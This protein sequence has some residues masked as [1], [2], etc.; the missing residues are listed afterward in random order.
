MESRG[1]DEELTPGTIGGRK[2]LI[3]GLGILGGGIAMARYL[4]DHGA[5]LRITDLRSAA[6]LAPALEALADVPAE[7]RLGAHSEADVRWA[8]VVIRNPGVR[9]DDRFLA[10]ARQLGRPVEMEMSFFFRWTP[11]RLTAVTGTKGKTTTTT[12][13]HNLLQADER[14]IHLTGNMGLPAI[15]LLDSLTPAD[16][17]LVEISCYQLEGMPTTG[18][19]PDV[20]LITNVDDDH[21]DRYGSLDEYA[22]VKASLTLGQNEAGWAV[23]PGWDQRL[24][25]L[26]AQ[27]KAQKALVYRDDDHDGEAMVGSHARIAIE[28]DTIR[29]HSNDGVSVDLCSTRDYGLVGYHNKLNLAFAAAGAFVNGVKPEAIAGM[30]PSLSPVRHRLEVVGEKD[31]IDFVNDSAASAPTAV[32]SALEAFNQERCVVI[33]GGVDKG[34]DFSRM[35]SAI[36]SHAVAAVL[37]PG[38]GSEVIAQQLADAHSD[39]PVVHAD[40]MPD[41]VAAAD[42]MAQTYRAT[43]VL[44]SPGCASFGLFL[45]EFDRGDQ[46]TRAVEELMGSTAGAA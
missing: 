3:L 12:L 9:S 10:F 34:S 37:L 28:G 8:D 2:V 44:L 7:Y 41:A 29:W 25:S 46:F 43:R 6:D 17:V 32:V 4:H 5:V 40:R 23:L 45:N 42:R 38:S 21:L 36:A 27:S 39:L 19:S 22:A 18:W 15:T 24:L 26:C 13:L 1:G 31:G 30:V 16:H 14:H 11:A 33:C 35:V 20:A